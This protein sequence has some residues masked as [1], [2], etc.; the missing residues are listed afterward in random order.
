M[1]SGNNVMSIIDQISELVNGCS[2]TKFKTGYVNVPKEQL[3]DL[4]QRL[5]EELPSAIARADKMVRNRQQILDDADKTR[6]EIENGAKAEAEKII[7]EANERAV[8]LVDENTST[9]KAE[10]KAS[11]ILTDANRR[12]TAIQENALSYANDIMTNFGNSLGNVF[13]QFKETVE[14][15]LR[16]MGAQLDE[17]DENRRQVEAALDASRGEVREEAPNDDMPDDGDDYDDQGD[18]QDDNGNYEES[19]YS[20]HGDDYRVSSNSL[21]DVFDDED[22]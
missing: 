22:Q 13:D 8:K 11:R 17:V 7:R 10:V 15:S 19:E 16:Q 1:A 5:S 18:Y 14:Q 6:K 9:M 12:A 4:V 20:E 2:P 3:L 21:D